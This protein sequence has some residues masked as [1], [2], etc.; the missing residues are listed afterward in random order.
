[1]EIMDCSLDKFYRQVYK[2]DERLPEKVI[3]FITASVRFFL[4]F[5]HNFVAFKVVRALNYLKE[6]LN[7]IHRGLKRETLL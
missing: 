4:F 2:H 3:G 7:L 1:M 6:V 5:K